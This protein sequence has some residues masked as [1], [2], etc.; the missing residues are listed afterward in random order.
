MQRYIDERQGQQQFY[1]DYLARVNNKLTIDDVL[2]DNN[3]GVLKGKV[4]LS[5]FM[6][7]YQYYRIVLAGDEHEIQITDYNPIGR[8]TYQEGDDA[9]LDFSAESVYIIPGT[10]AEAEE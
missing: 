9:A 5:T 7:S 3:D 1:E 2:S 4:T 8:K 10:G 6:G